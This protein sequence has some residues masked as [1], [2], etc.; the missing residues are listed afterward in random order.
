MA[1]LFEDLLILLVVAIFL[2]QIVLP[3]A[4]GW[5]VLLS[6]RGGIRSIASSTAPTLPCRRA[7]A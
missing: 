1:V 4:M 6:I 7:A 2:S 3:A 5:A